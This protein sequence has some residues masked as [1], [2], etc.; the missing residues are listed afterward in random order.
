M[1]RPNIYVESAFNSLVSLPFLLSFVPRLH[2]LGG[3]VSPEFGCK[4]DNSCRTDAGDDPDISM[5][6]SGNPDL[7]F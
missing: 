3:I 7:Q 5:N 2:N 4:A 6:V 1:G